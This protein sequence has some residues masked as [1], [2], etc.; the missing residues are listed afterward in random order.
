MSK[1]QFTIVADEEN[2]A[3]TFWVAFDEAYPEIA[4]QFR[5][6]GSVTVDEETWKAIQKL[7]GF[8]DGPEYAPNAVIVSASHQ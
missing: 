7:E 4:T 8:G 3:E 5:H 2:N 1:E 6:G